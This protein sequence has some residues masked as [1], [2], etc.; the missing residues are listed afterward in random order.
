MSDTQ[1]ERP[2][3]TLPD[4]PSDRDKPPAPGAKGVT[5]VALD[6]AGVSPE[7]ARPTL[8]M[9]EPRPVRVPER[10]GPSPR[11]RK[12]ALGAG[13]T[14]G[15][16]SLGLVLARE[17]L[18]RWLIEREVEERGFRVVAI[19]GLSVGFGNAVVDKL[20]LEASDA[21]GV[22]VRAKG[23]AGW[24]TGLFRYGI[25]IDECEIEASE[26]PEVLARVAR[27]AVAREG[28]GSDLQI[29]EARFVWNLAPFGEVLAIDHAKLKR[30]P[31]RVWSVSS[32]EVRV[33][34]V[35]LGAGAATIS[36]AEARLGLGS[37]TLDS[38]LLLG[39]VAPLDAPARL[40]ITA[41]D[42]SVK[43]LFFPSSPVPAWARR[44]ADARLD[45]DVKLEKNQAGVFAGKVTGALAGADLDLPNSVASLLAGKPTLTA[46][47][48][49]DPA[50]QTLSI[51]PA[52]VR[53]GGLTLKGGVDAAKVEGGATAKGQVSGSLPCSQLAQAA[54]G[55][56]GGQLG[57]LAGSILGA[58]VQGSVSVSLAID[59]DSRK[60]ASAKLSPSVSVGCTGPGF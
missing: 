14:L 49:F 25:E 29:K 19:D 43:R 2:S 9:E 5:E 18:A 41:N 7:R 40:S 23:V 30:S 31:E 16:A 12:V 53:L 4:H 48:V 59:V 47:V 24:L 51:R 52:Q 28:T 60:L 13:V 56:L 3:P 22:A 27:N 21:P 1:I 39:T 20:S 6:L 17:P 10:R 8:P 57:A 45:L 26:P 38:A 58:A 37:L 55:G 35:P 11:W 32:P 46:D 42:A 34:R 36:K 50:A 15:A 54:G 33:L 44:V